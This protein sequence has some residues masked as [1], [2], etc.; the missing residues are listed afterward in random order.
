MMLKTMLLLSLIPSLIY[1]VETKIESELIFNSDKM[2]TYFIWNNHQY[3]IWEAQHDPD[4]PCNNSM[5]SGRTGD[6]IR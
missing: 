2:K 4:C 3:I 5:G 6:P 1:S